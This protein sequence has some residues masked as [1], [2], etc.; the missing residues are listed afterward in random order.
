MRRVAVT[1][2]GVVTPTGVGT[3]A[4]WDSLSSGRS[5]ISAIEHFDASA[6]S[7]RFGGYVRDFDPSEVI[8]KKEARR[9]SRFQQFAMVAADQAMREAGLTDI[10][11]A[12]SLRAGC[13]VG[14]GIGGLGTME[15]QTA[16]LLERG[17]SRI[18]P[19]LVPMMIVDLAAGHISI[20]YGLRGINY[21]PVS[22][23]ATGSHAIGEAAEVIRRGD[24]DLVVAGG[25][26]AG[27]T[28]LGVA[29]FAAAR[30]LSQ[31]NDDPTGASRPW[32]SGR[33][34][35]VI[36]E[37]GGL[38]VL[39]DWD[40]A[41]ARGA[42][43]RA[44][45]LGYGAT[46]DAYHITAPAPDGN[47]AIRAM[48]QALAQAGLEPSDVGYIN[49]HGTS[50]EVGD[51]AETNAIKAVFGTDAP[52]VSSTKSMMGH[53]LGGAGAAEAA[54]CVLAMENG[55]VPP[56]IN[57]TDPDPAC[58]LDYVPNVARKADLKVT[59]SNSFGFGGHNAT[60]VLGRP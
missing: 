28:P 39:E 42:H 48:E 47:G 44:E 60:L 40:S 55:L 46:A 17:P 54:V 37:G 25:F 15:D 43:I 33:D 3:T 52:L 21:A 7:T 49:A 2:I 13:I 8:D 16:I 5:G 41:V 10:G 45:V 4:M 12:L 51:L 32:D 30:A 56:T 31:R 22:A 36:S 6:Y 59:M 9:M 53:M 14:S 20:R 18:S 58:D 38:F 27:V 29:G 35:F 24:A 1:G 11:E 34:G 19:F 57:L 23:C 26:D 50:T